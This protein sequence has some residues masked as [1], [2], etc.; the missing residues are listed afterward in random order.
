MANTD[1]AVLLIDISTASYNLTFELVYL[2]IC[3]LLL[4]LNLSAGHKKKKK[5]K[6]KKKK[7]EKHQSL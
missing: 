5:E 1:C 3:L 4:L 6:K 2:S 7:K